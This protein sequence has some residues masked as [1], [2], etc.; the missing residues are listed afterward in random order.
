M[1]K[2]RPRSSIYVCIGVA[3][4]RNCKVRVKSFLQV[5]THL[6]HFKLCWNIQEE[7][8]THSNY[9]GV[10]I[11]VPGKRLENNERHN[12]DIGLVQLDRSVIIGSDMSPIC[13]DNTQTMEVG[14]DVVYISGF[15]IT[16]YRENRTSTIPECSTNHFLPRPFHSWVLNN[17]SLN[18]IIFLFS[19][20][21]KS[22]CFKKE[23][24]PTGMKKSE[25]F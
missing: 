13:L 25:N 19:I 24:P 21:C 16:F 12:Y 23:S 20:G 14:E 1:R 11:I 2:A 4:E 18:R 22:E 15:G 8:K 9:L 3:H 5:H 10:K 17:S 7:I 6:I